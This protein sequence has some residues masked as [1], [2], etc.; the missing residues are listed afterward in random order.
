M[1]IY[2]DENGV[3]QAGLECGS[4]GSDRVASAKNGGLGLASVCCVV[5]I[6]VKEE[7]AM[8]HWPIIGLPCEGHASA[9]R[10]E[11]WK[12]CLGLGREGPHRCLDRRWLRH[13]ESIEN[14]RWRGRLRETCRKEQIKIKRTS[15]RSFPS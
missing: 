2:L 13:I 14:R 5:S 8:V 3:T 4:I 10:W 11:V 7:S 12:G 6:L 15:W 1:W 9:R